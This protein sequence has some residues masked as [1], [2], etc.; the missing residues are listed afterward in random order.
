MRYLKKAQYSIVRDIILFL[1]LLGESNAMQPS[2]NAN[3]VMWY[4]SS[5]S[6][7]LEK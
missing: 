6:I 7:F 5:S 2:R 4:S 3:S 1:V